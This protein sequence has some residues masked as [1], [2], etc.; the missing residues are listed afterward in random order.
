MHT[1]ISGLAEPCE[2]PWRWLQADVLEIGPGEPWVA[3][4]VH[5]DAAGE[6]HTVW[7]ERS[8]LPGI[9]RG[10]LSGNMSVHQAVRSVYLELTTSQTWN[11]WFAWFEQQHGLLEPLP[12]WVV[13]GMARKSIQRNSEVH[14]AGSARK[15]GNYRRAMQRA[16]E[17]LAANH[18]DEYETLLEQF[19][20]LE[21]LSP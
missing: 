11:S 21:A 2:A 3:V 15:H 10:A 4:R 13:R 18:Q 8:P 5:F 16:Q 20:V 14:A 6:W 9:Q 19:L 12:D 17:T 1:W 7:F